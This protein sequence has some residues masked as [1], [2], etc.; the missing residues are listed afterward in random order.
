[1]LSKRWEIAP[2]NPRVE[3]KLA[4][5][6]QIRPLAAR[7][8]VNRGITSIDAAREFLTPSLQRLHDPFLMR[9]MAEAVHRLT[10]SLQNQESIVIY[11]DYDVDGITA[12]AV[13]SWFFR[14][15]GV[16]VP[17]YLPHRMREGY[18]L[19]A[20]AVRSL[21][22]RARVSSSLSIAASPVIM[23]SNSLEAWE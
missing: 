10:R 7:L 5:A 16:S 23:R 11:G 13:L 9:G 18:G 4:A 19:N 22:I 8:L 15:I 14:D 6:L 2:E 17:Y 1:M 21:P 20:E 12:T 3:E